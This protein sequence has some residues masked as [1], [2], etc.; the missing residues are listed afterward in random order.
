MK[1]PNKTGFGRLGLAF[2]QV[3]LPRELESMKDNL[4]RYFYEALNLAEE[5]NSALSVLLRR[6]PD[7]LRCPSMDEP[8]YKCYCD[9]SIKDVLS[10]FFMMIMKLP[11]FTGLKADI[12]VL[13][14][15]IADKDSR[16]HYARKI[17]HGA[18][19]TFIIDVGIKL[20]DPYYI[21]NYPL[22]VSMDKVKKWVLEQ[23]PSECMDYIKTSPYGLM[24]I[25]GYAIECYYRAAD[26]ITMVI[27]LL[28]R[29]EKY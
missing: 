19:M 27:A 12:R 28:M 3:L 21:M 8:D 11:E 6:I 2:G 13:A 16:V 23:I 17:L 1:R 29:I 15:H 22:T 14:T 4:L 5:G 26:R 18:D 24:G 10:S 9:D 20:V 7:D 25:L